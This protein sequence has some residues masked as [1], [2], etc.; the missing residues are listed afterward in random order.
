MKKSLSVM[1]VAGLALV[2]GT[3]VGAGTSDNPG[4]AWLDA[5]TDP[6]AINVSGT[7]SSAELGNMSLSQ[8]HGSR[9]VTGINGSYVLTGVVSDKQ[10]FLLIGDKSGDVYKCAILNS[11][12][13]DSLKGN[14]YY[15]TS[16]L[17]RGGLCQDKGYPLHLKKQ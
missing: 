11:E 13:S 14:Y 2:F 4:K 12:G 6:A 17:N 16:R 15:R 5:Q 3:A 9:E 10:L 1:L 7:W 8:A